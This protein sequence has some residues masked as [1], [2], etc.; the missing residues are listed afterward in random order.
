MAGKI[1]YDNLL[2]MMEEKRLTTYKIRK[3]KI[4]SE[5]T[6]QNIR[7]GKCITTDAVASLCEAL[8]CQPG[9]ILKYVPS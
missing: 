3:N 6:L 8:D 4:I 1:V 7:Q 9:D 5:S 2:T